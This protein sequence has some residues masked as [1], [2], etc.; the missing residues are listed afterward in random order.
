MYMIVGFCVG[1]CEGLPGVGI[2]DMLESGLRIE[3]VP[4]DINHDRRV[5]IIDI[6]ATARAFGSML[7]D[8]RWNDDADVQED[9]TINIIDMSIVAKSFGTT[10]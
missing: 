9:G 10:Y 3:L 5:N 4:P 1:R 8:D 7:G 2:R 6:A